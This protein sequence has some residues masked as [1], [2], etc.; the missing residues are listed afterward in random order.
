MAPRS[1]ATRCRAAVQRA[2]I[3]AAAVDDVIMGCAT[4]EG[5]T[6][7]NIARQIALRAGLPVT[8]VGHDH[9]PLL[10]VRP[11]DHRD[12]C[13]RIIAGEGEVYVAGGV[14]SISC[15]QNEANSH[16]LRD[17]ARQAQARDLLVDA[18]DR[19]EGGQALQHRPR[20]MDEYGAASQQT[21]TAALEA[22]KS[23]TRSRRSPAGRRGR[24]GGGPAHE[25]SHHRERRR[26]PRR[27]HQGR[28]SGIR[29]RCRAA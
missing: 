16:M 6:G 11:A 22:G 14:E 24:S 19:R 10:L 12:R 17:L 2:G 27:H 8:T 25:G 4:P 18:G 23:R 7:G 20:A 29:R 21:A 15:V 13:A 1:A 9:Q 5:A 28:H 3:D 26:H